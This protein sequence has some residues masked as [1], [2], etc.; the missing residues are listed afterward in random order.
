MSENIY[1]KL[2]GQTLVYGL[3]TMI[4][5]VLNYIILTP[6]F[7][8]YVFK[9]DMNEYGKLTELYAYLSFLIILLTYGMETAYFRFYNKED[10]KDKVFSTIITSVF[11]T[12]LA[13]ILL[14]TVFIKKICN[15]LKY[16]NE[17][18]L[19]II[20]AA[21]VAIEAFSA[22]PFAKLRVLEK[23][24]K[25]A[26]FKGINIFVNILF[27]LFFYNFLPEIGLKELIE[28]SHGD[29]SVKF[30][31]L[32][33]LLTSSIILLMLLP[34]LRE[35]AIKKVN[36]NLLRTLL[37]FGWPLLIAGFAGIINESLDRSILKQL[38]P[39]EIKGLHDLA[40]YGANYKIAAFILLFIQIYRFA[41]EPFFFNYEK[42]NDSKRQYA[43]LMNL[44]VGITVFMGLFIM[45][46]LNYIK[47]FVPSAYQEGLGVVPYIIIAYIFSGIYYNHSV[48]FKL[49]EKTIYAVYIASIGAIATIILNVVYV[50]K[51]SYHASA[52]A[53]V[54]AYGL[55]VIFSFIFS[56]RYYYIKYNLKRIILYFIIGIGLVILSKL[57]DIRILILNLTIKTV[58]VSIFAIFVIWREGLLKTFQRFKR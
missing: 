54:I 47:Y 32:A 20:L 57:I 29:V 44:F 7:T 30:V 10:V 1:R 58:I 14:V 36:W 12:S 48:W 2:G 22:I 49:S 23:A 5:R 38:I 8:Y 42:N 28:N 13:F 3:G 17:K 31:L 43:S 16:S 55:M 21:I 26:L 35:F 18:D 53:T 24:K 27:I 51:Y 6:Y 19:I 37:K 41:I 46:F 33:N 39:N 4:P 40:V 11:T 56:V 15:F 50:P 34:E 52:V 25:F 45:V 9:N